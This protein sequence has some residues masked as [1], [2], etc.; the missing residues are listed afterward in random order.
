MFD[1][2]EGNPSRVDRVI[3][4]VFENILTGLWPPGSR[5][6]EMQ[7]AEFFGISRTPVR[8]AIRRM[9]EMGILV[10]HPRCKLEIAIVDERDL[11]EIT[12]LRETLESYA[13]S[14]AQPR[15]SAEDLDR[16][17]ACQQTCEALLDGD[18]LL[19]IFRQDGIFHQ[20][21]AAISGNRYL[22][23][24]LDWLEVK[25]LLC[26]ILHCRAP[27][28]VRASVLFHR[29]ILQTL[30]AGDGQQTETLLRQHINGTIYG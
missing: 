6:T 26:R 14:L 27:E 21:L 16:L 20:T 13:L 11:L 2:V 10:A 9:T 30:R 12:Q 8:E 25:I 17:D 1:T 3:T 28:K 5:I 24:T 29:T 23:E 4:Q 18:D 15:I 19:A 7:M 22:T